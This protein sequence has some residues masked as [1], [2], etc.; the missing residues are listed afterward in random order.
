M[1]TRYTVARI[2]LDGH[3]FEIIVNPELALKYKLGEKVSIQKLLMSDL[4]FTDAKKGLKASSSL[5]KKYFK[6]E[7]V[8]KIA[9]RILKYGEIQITTEQRR[10]LIKEKRRAIVALI[11]AHCIDPRTGVKVPSTRV[12]QA[13]NQ[14]RVSIDPFKSA[15]DQVKEIIKQVQRVLPLKFEYSE[16]ELLVPPSIIEPVKHLVHSYGDML[17]EKNLP[18][19]RLS[20]RVA[21]PSLARSSFLQKLRKEFSHRVEEHLIK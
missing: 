8:L 7:D 6:T 16:F 10:R 5:L 15:E 20:L 4:V 19:G 12:E 13:L 1:P 14:A 18:D 11:S 3:R 17:A 21:L 9:E 2:T